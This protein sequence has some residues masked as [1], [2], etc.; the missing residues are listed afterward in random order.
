V[1]L[2]DT[3]RNI[4]DDA[5]YAA[6]SPEKRSEVDTVVAEMH[7]VTVSGKPMPAEIVDRVMQLMGA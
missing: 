3:R 6:L 2:D 4:F 1:S 7:A 5:T